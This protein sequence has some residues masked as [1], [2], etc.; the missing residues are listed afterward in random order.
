MPNLQ[1]HWLDQ[2]D[3]ATHVWVYQK[4]RWEAK[5]V[6]PLRFIGDDCNSCGI[7]YSES[8]D[9][10]QCFMICMA[11]RHPEFHASG[12]SHHTGRTDWTNCQEGVL[13]VVRYIYIYWYIMCNM[14]LVL[15]FGEGLLVDG[16]SP[17]SL[18]MYIY[19]YV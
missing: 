8:L 12:F 5:L 15:G 13:I 10:N 9:A 6:F 19:I 7:Q 1:S 11:K 16:R 14:A 2:E 18:W 4:S 17:A 3:F